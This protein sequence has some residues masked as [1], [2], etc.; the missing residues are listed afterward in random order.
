MSRGQGRLFQ[1][2]NGRGDKSAVWWMDYTVGGVRHRESSDMTVR[3]DANTVMQGRIGERVSGKVTGNPDKITLG[4]LRDLVVQ[5]YALDGNRSVGR[6]KSAFAT[7]IGFFGEQETARKL[8][9]LRLNQYAVHRLGTFVTRSLT[10]VPTRGRQISRATVNYELAMLRRGFNL[11]IEAGLLS[12]KPVFDL[13]DPNNARQGYFEEGELAAVLLELPA[14]ARRDIVQFLRFTGWRSTEGRLL[15][16]AE[17]DM[18]AETIRLSPARAKSKKGRLFPF[19]LAPELRAVMLDRW[20]QREGPFV[21]H[22]DGAA[23]E[24]GALRSAWAKAVKRAGVPDRIIHDLRR[25]VA[26][27]F[28]NAGVD[29]ETIK[30]LC[31]WKTDAMFTRY[32]IVD[33]SDLASAVAKRYGKPTA[34]QGGA[35]GRQRAVTSSAA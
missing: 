35:A 16:W 19:G 9:K 3:K 17:V 11:A 22:R 23:I 5:Q 27:D 8:D 4:Q 32:L 7:L 15:T 20:A 25:G 24:K 12:T 34:R 30:K 21:F 31:G 33:E 28:T 26:R 29:R 6:V 1:P 13:P 18:S 2:I 10:K 14:D